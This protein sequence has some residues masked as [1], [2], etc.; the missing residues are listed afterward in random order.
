MHIFGK[1]IQ[2]AQLN[3]DFILTLELPKE[4]NSKIGNIHKYLP[5]A[6]ASILKTCTLVVSARIHSENIIV[7][8]TEACV[9]F[10]SYGEESKLKIDFPAGAVE[11]QCCLEVQVYKLRIV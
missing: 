1:T 11:A 9:F 3:Y 4:I 8:P 7:Q 5:V 2:F 10:K 6:K